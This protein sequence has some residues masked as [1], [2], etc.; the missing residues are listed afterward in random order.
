MVTVWPVSPAIG[1]SFSNHWLPAAALEV[2]VVLPPWQKDEVPVMT[3]FAGLG[4]MVT[5]TAVDLLSQ[6]FT[7][8]VA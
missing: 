4:R 5:V 6:P 2:K 1:L 7:V 3:G 8:W